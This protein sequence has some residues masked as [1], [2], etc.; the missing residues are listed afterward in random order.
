MDVPKIIK[1]STA[2][3]QHQNAPLQEYHFDAVQIEPPL[4]GLLDKATLEPSAELGLEAGPEPKT[5]MIASEQCKD[6]DCKPVDHP[7]SGDVTG[8]QE[9]QNVDPSISRSLS[10][11]CRICQEDDTSEELISPCFCTG[12][13]GHMHF[14]C[15]EK[16]LQANSRTNCELCSYPFP[17]SKVLP[18]LSVYLRHP[19]KN[20]DMPSL[21]CDVSCFFLLTPLLIASTYLCSV[22]VGHYH[23]IGKSESVFAVIT[24]MISL[25]TVYCAW[26]TLAI[27]YHR[28]VWLTWRDKN[29][30]IHMLTDKSL[31]RQPVRRVEEI[32]AEADSTTSDSC[33][34]TSRQESA[35]ILLRSFLMFTRG[36]LTKARNPLASINI[37]GSNN[38]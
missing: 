1:E 12:S 22:G 6:L 2:V 35:S 10:T 17:V 16:W 24:L 21:L 26:A 29:A 15:L 38:T 14:T 30:E 13:V 28:K 5:P 19:G 18:S 27:L 7:G 34:I 32:D 9:P 4:I 36:R 25:I 33:G 37:V 11:C 20:M 8:S 3:C 31:L 23:V